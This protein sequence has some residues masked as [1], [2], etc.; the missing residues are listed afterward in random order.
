MFVF[1]FGV[2]ILPVST[3]VLLGF[4]IY[5]TFCVFHLFYFLSFGDFTGHFFIS[6]QFIIFVV[7]ILLYNC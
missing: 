1:V 3:I 2:S 6:V 4:G 7:F 5:G